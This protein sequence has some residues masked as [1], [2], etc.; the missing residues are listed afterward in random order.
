MEVVYFSNSISAMWLASGTD[1]NNDNTVRKFGINITQTT[2]MSGNSRYSVQECTKDSKQ[3]S[4]GMFWPTL[5][6]CMQTF[7]LS[8][9][10]ESGLQYLV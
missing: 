9:I 7:C 8:L 10:R 4:V 6:L 5:K 1:D 2:V 3:C